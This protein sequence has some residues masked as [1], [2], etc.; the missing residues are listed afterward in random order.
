MNGHAP[1]ARGTGMHVLLTADAVGGVFSYATTLAR[2]LCAMGMRVTFVLQGPPADPSRLAA[3]ADVPGIDVIATDLQLEWLDPDGRDFARA[4]RQLETIASSVRPDVVHFNGFREACSDID[5]PRV[6]VAH[7]CVGSWW[8]AC[9]GSAPDASWERYE[10]NLRAGLQ[11]ANA[12]AAPSRWYR[13]RVAALHH[14]RREGRVIYNGISPREP[15]SS[16]EP[17]V[18]SA[19]R[20]WDEA[21]DL[22]TLV[23]A[24]DDICWPVVIAGPLRQDGKSGGA[25]GGAAQMLGE[26][27]P[28]DLAA[29]MACAAIF[30]S[31]AVYEP[32]GLAVLE[33]A[34][35]GC[36]LVLADTPSF[37]EIW[38]D[39]AQY[40][41]PRDSAALAAET[42]RLAHDDLLRRQKGNRASARARRYSASRMCEDTAALYASVLAPAHA[43]TAA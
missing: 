26:L 41:A 4:C 33:A 1:T 22:A 30:V 36:A 38:G 15:G 5:A 10:I 13:D 29:H 20:M 32:F 34:A 2:G 28:A 24:A 23:R 19:G 42:N 6:L 16:H 40:F 27:S 39:A 21:K 31:S 43:E 8:R 9:R 11:A 18:L 14:Q 12:W 7:S 17:L 25:S 35:S 37:R 3:L